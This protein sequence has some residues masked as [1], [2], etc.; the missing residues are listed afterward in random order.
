MLFILAGIGGFIAGFVYTFIYDIT[1]KTCGIIHIDHDTEQ[2]LVQI[3]S[4][5]LSNR[6]VK[7]VVFTVNHDAEISREE[8]IL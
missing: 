8:Q 5:E 7:K 3:T 6:K 1:H 4:D 2:L